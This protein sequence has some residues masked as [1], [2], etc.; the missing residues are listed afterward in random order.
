MIRVRLAA[1]AAA[2]LAG[3]SAAGAQTKE[4]IIGHFGTP[5]PMH[6]AYDEI[7]KATGYKISW[8]KF[9]AG[10]DVIAAMASGSIKI[11]EL[12]SS[13]L[14]I[15]ASQGVDYQLFAI[16]NVIGAAEALVARNGS[17]INKLADIKGKKIGVPLGSTAHFSLMGAMR[18][19]KVDPKSVTVLGMKPDQIAAAWSQK[20]ID[21][22]Y[23]WDPAL[24]KIK[25]DG[26]VIT[27]SGEVAKWGN[28][29]FDG[30]VVNPKWAKENE[31][32]M[33]AFLKT[34]DKVNGKYRSNGAKWTAAT[35]EAVAIAKAT[36][37]KPQD[38]V[39]ALKGYQFPSAKEQASAAWLGKSS[40][41]GMLATAKFLAAEKRIPKALGD[42]KKF[43]TADYLKKAAK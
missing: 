17:G 2:L 26:K 38:V 41:E 10:T 13:P 20:Q 22:A 5:M 19:A 16:S 11:A 35:P 8:R 34:L 3:I 12:G 9:D 31:A 14:A 15:G 33:V 36:G 28:P 21:A 43:V 27:H 37:S 7:A 30:W 24:A 6:S 18:H 40:A 25:A 39:D 42:Y 32:F 1:A 29:T 4:V 23:V